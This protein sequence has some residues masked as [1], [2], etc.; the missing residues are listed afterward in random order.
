[1]AAAVR[2]L[3]L[4][5]CLA[6][7]SPLIGQ[8][9]ARWP[10]EI[11]IFEKQGEWLAIAEITS[12]TIIQQPWFYWM[13]VG[14]TSFASG[15]WIEWLAKKSDRSRRQKS[16]GRTLVSLA[17]RIDSAQDSPESK[18]PWSIQHVRVDLQSALLKLSGVGLWVPDHTIFLRRDANMLVSYLT[19]IGTSLAEGRFA[20]AREE[21][22][23]CRD[24]LRAERAQLRSTT[25]M[26]R[27]GR[28]PEYV[29]VVSARSN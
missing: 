25:S 9:A 28:R 29:R 19:V 5:I 11:S 8:F 12:L 26:P 18:W 13:L 1:M 6:A 7:S 16:L 22:F 20:D 24:L 4:L 2:W 21:S 10:K 3:S 23:R 14:L 27:E 17:Q 15:I